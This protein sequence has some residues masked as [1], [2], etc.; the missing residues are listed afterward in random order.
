MPTLERPAVNIKQVITPASPTVL[1]PTLVPCIVGP[2]YQI[3]EPLEDGAL[4]SDALITTAAELSADNAHVA[5]ATLSGTTLRVTI[6][7]TLETVVFP[8]IGG[9]GGFSQALI[10]NA[11]NA[12]LSLAYAEYGADNILRLF[13]YAKGTAATIVIQ[14]VGV[15]VLN[16]AASPL[17]FTT[18]QSV[19]GKAQY[20][21]LL[22]R[23]P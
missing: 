10:V 9:A 8:V 17:G 23:V 11:L 19:A 6:N 2:C 18:S 21:N 13:T 22:Y 16:T 4:N 14:A 7:G 20:N 3:V 12:G 5:P 15:D 1:T